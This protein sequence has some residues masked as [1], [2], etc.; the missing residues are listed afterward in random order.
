MTTRTVVVNAD[1]FGLHPAATAGIL[2][3]MQ[4]G[5]VTS[6]SVMVNGSASSAALACARQHQLDVGWHI[7]LTHGRPVCA[8]DTI[9]S[10]VDRHGNFH[11]LPT[12][13]RRAWCGQLQRADVERELAAQWTLLH[14]GIG[15]PSHVNGHHHVHVLPVI[16]DVV[17]AL[18]QQ[19]RIPWVRLPYERGGLRTPRTAARF[20]LAAQRAAHPQFWADSG[21]A[22]L[23]F[24]GLSLGADGD[25]LD[26]WEQLCARISTTDAEIMVHPA[27]DDDSG[28]DFSGDRRGELQ[29]LLSPAWRTLMTSH[30]FRLAG[31]RALTPSRAAS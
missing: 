25:R 31:F 10:L 29:I 21:A 1:D 5:V 16:C 3:A 9:P 15:Q 4:A 24:Y 11:P 2:A 19:H 7:T 28:D 23:P 12:L 27:A 22:F 17:K 14:A 8:P 30:G 20:F 26:A 6:T 13:I 18:V